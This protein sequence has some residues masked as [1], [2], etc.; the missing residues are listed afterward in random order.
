M[1]SI[2][3]NIN[4]G[5]RFIALGEEYE[6]IEISRGDIR[7]AN[8]KGGKMCVLSFEK[9][10]KH[11]D[12]SKFKIKSNKQNNDIPTFKIGSEE[13]LR[14]VNYRLKFIRA[15][16]KHCKYRFSNAHAKKFLNKHGKKIAG[17][18]GRV[19]SAQTLVRW[20]TEYFK[21]D[22]DPSS[23]KTKYHKRVYRNFP[24]AVEQIIHEEI[25]KCY[26]NKQR[27]SVQTIKSNVKGRI[28]AEIEDFKKGDVPSDKTFYRRIKRYDSYTTY[29]KRYGQYQ[30][31]KLYKAAGR[32]L[33]ASRPLEVVEADGNILDVQIIDETGVVIGRP[34]LTALIDRYTR[35]IIAAYISMAPF[36]AAT[37]MNAVKQ[38][39]SASYNSFGG[40]IE[41]LVVDN[42]GDFISDAFKS[43]CE[44]LVSSI[45]YAEPYGH[46]DKPFIERFFHTMNTQFIH[47]LPGT[48][49][50]NPKDRGDYDSV[51][52]AS[53]TKPELERLLK[54]WIETVYH[55][56]PHRGLVGIPSKRWK[57]GLKDFPIHAFDYEDAD[58]FSR[59]IKQRTIHKGR[60]QIHNLFWYSHALAS[61]EQEYKNKHARL[62]V[63]VLIDESDLDIVYIRHPDNSDSY[64]QADSTRPRYT[65]DLSL[66][67]HN[68]IRE[69]LKQ[70]LAEDISKQ[71][72]Y[73]LDKARH[74]LW[75]EIQEASKAGRNKI[76]RLRDSARKVQQSQL[77]ENKE[78]LEQFP[79]PTEADIPPIVP[80]TGIVD[81]TF[82]V[83]GI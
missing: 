56:S 63:D 82:E 57:R 25:S 72:D 18:T 73:T 35:C 30:A 7:Y 2:S 1:N 76:N 43:S 51:K 52:Y 74:D 79:N 28:T 40:R 50:S 6:V 64:I 83:R 31:N 38:G 62:V 3:E 16:E 77:V 4:I 10:E 48:T 67:E 66:Y 5:T 33:E 21:H 47:T 44:R 37:L 19:P 24:D 14:T 46:D 8:T 61:I 60:V 27:L 68:H 49:F 70:Q 9:F 13:Q 55:E 11:L 75:K 81:N 32:S 23:L 42:G 39:V 45:E 17:K 78:D 80:Q 36:S 53:I 20:N 12:N 71:G 58:K 22:G 54:Q 26:Q 59:S 34:Y 29:K 15:A 65:K 41:C 69:R